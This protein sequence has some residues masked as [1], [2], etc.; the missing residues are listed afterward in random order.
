MRSGY[1]EPGTIGAA[2]AGKKRRK[3]RKWENRGWEMG[4]E[5]V[6]NG[7]TEGGKQENRG[8]EMG[9]EGAR[10]GRRQYK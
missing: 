10:S 2:G 8:W 9:E 3:S 7:R 1:G 4:E 6:E 5:M